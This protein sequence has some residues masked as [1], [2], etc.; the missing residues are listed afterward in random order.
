MENPFDNP[1]T[2]RSPESFVGRNQLLERIL[3][4]IKNR[5]NASLVGPRRIGKTSLLTCLRDETIQ[6]KFNFDGSGFAFLYLDLQRWSM[7]PRI[8]FLDD[9]IQVL[10]EQSQGYVGEETLAKDDEFSALLRKFAQRGLYPVLLIDTFDEIVRYETMDMS[11]FYLLRS[12]ATSGGISFITAS[13]ES[14]SKL[15]RKLF[16][17]DFVG[18]PF[19]NIFS[20]I[21]L[22]TFY[23]KEARTL[24]TTF[25]ERGGLPFNEQEVNWVLEMAGLHPFLLQQV[26]ALLFQEKMAQVCG[27]EEISFLRIR[28]EALRNL[29]GYFEDCWTFLSDDERQ[30]LYQEV[31]QRDSLVCEDA[32]YPELSFSRLFQDYLHLTGELIDEISLEECKIILSQYGDLGA[33][34]ES[35]IVKIP[36]IA[37]RIREHNA[38]S[39]IS[40]GKIVQRV[41]REALESIGG[42]EQH[43]DVSRDWIDYNILYYRYFMFRHDLSQERIASRL[44]ISPSQYYRLF[45]KAIERLW[46]ALLAIDGDETQSQG[47]PTYRLRL[48]GT[49][50]K[51]NLSMDNVSIEAGVPPGLIQ[52]MCNDPDYDPTLYTMLAIADYLKMPINT[53]YERI[54]EDEDPAP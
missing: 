18:S 53:L 26:A 40:K 35:A 34:G 14:P 46:Q 52:R 36:S 5:Q 16:Y 21:K 29:H 20:M 12:H 33:L 27:L 45:P 49:L 22:S 39:S 3:G 11:L 6:K 41:L 19:F 30:R 4:L 28:K 9:V 23:L 25:S 31:Q 38:L 7:K 51:R 24:L 15:F 1:T 13:L 43:S 37:A 50:K 17:G 48:K 42:H 8:D 44:C 54:K 10:K 47:K 2:I 32:E